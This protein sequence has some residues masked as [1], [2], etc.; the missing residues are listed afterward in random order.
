MNNV[1]IVLCCDDFGELSFGRLNI[2]HINKISDEQTRSIF[3]NIECFGLLASDLEIENA[4]EE[5]LKKNNTNSLKELQKYFLFFARIKELILK[6]EESEVFFE[7]G[8]YPRKL[9]IEEQYY[10]RR[11]A[12]LEIKKL[13]LE[14]EIISEDLPKFNKSMMNNQ[15]L[16]K[17]YKEDINEIKVLIN[18]KSF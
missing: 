4:C 16:S 6:E 5:Y 14:D 7:F 2:A 18:I 11:D 13:I 15:Y 1:K 3:K 9:I 10:I 12:F 8:L 17:N